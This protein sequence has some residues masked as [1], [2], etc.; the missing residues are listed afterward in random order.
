MPG[1]K[2]SVRRGILE[3]L[4]YCHAS[5]RKQLTCSLSTMLSNEE[6]CE[7]PGLFEEIIARISSSEHKVLFSGLLGLHELVNALR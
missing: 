6:K 2:E 1:D 5:S 4:A 7:W 3:A